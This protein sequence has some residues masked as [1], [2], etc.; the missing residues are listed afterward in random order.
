MKRLIVTCNGDVLTS[1]SP[2]WVLIHS[3]HRCSLDFKDNISLDIVPFK[4][5]SDIIFSQSTDNFIIVYV[6]K[7]LKK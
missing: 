3:Y 5:H 7:E 1:T 4:A 2:L 6:R